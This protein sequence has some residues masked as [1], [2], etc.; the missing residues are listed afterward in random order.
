MKGGSA[1]LVGKQ[2]I[3]D[4]LV[5]LLWDV[6]YDIETVS[7]RARDL[8]ARYVLAQGERHPMEAIPGW[9]ASERMN[10][11]ITPRYHLA[12]DEPS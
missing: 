4:T 5:P 10:P 1:H 2:Q 12:R 11:D 9:H 3:G 7:P 6:G 8:V